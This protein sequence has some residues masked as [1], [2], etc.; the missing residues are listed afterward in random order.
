MRKLVRL[1]LFALVAPVFLAGFQA[2]QTQPGEHHKQLDSLAGSW[3]VAITFRLGNGPERHGSATCEARWILGG[4]FLEQQYKSDSGLEVRQ[5]VGYDNQKK[6]FFEVKFDNSDTGVLHTEGTI[7]D[8]GKRITNFG[9]RLDPV[10]GKSARLRT[11]TTIIDG[12]HFTIE[13]FLVGA[14]GVEQRTVLMA[15]SRK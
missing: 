5:F 4:R 11:V 15:H 3:N 2:H 9:D 8:D 14:D 13:W 6:K 10:T 7:S 1:L 12:D